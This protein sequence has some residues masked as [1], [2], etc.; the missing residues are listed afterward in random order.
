MNIGQLYE[1]LRNIH[2][3]CGKWW[4]GKSEEVFISAILTQ[5]TNWANVEKALGNIKAKLTNVNDLDGNLLRA[6]SALSDD[7]IRELIRPAGFFNVKA[8][9]LR[10]SLNW[11]SQYNFDIATVK[12]KVQD[13]TGLKAL[14]NELL[15][16]NGIGKE[17]ADSILCYGLDLPVFVVDAYTKRLISRIFALEGSEIKDYDRVQQ[18]FESSY[19]RDVAIYQELHGLIVEHAKAYCKSKPKCDECPLK[20]CSYKNT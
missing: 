10:N 16:I 13:E 5:N 4:P 11:I 9:R 12:R 20:G 2:G 18:I 17:T 7:E 3:S 15:S 19:P 6:L 14:R 8:R 1:I